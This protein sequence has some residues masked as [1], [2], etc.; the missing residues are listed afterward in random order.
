LARNFPA[1]SF[2]KAPGAQDGHAGYSDPLDE[3]VFMTQVINFVQQ[4]PE[5]I[6]TAVIVLWDD[7]DGWYDHAYV[8]PTHPS[9]DLQVDRLNGRGRCG[10][11]TAPAGVSGAPVNGRCGPGTRIPLLVISPWAK[12]N[13]VDHT[14]IVASSVIRF[15]EDNWLDGR[16]LGGGSFDATAGSIMG[17]FDFRGE[18]R[19]DKLFLS[20]RTGTIIESPSH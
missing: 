19:S 14:P 5:W 20:P 15:I 10:R 2:L 8:S 13:F 16:R 17:M 3:Q 1:V 11:G 9:F 18:P 7:S 12:Q 6:S 4:Q